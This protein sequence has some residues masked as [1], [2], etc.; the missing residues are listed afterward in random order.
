MRL[1]ICIILLI[2]IRTGFAQEIENAK[3]LEDY[4]VL[5]DK[6]IE[7]VKNDSSIHYL[8]KALEIS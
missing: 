6:S 3:L 2:I 1:L 4:S 7:A 5:A 8:N